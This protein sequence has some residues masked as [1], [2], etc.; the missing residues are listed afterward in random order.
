M[1]TSDAWTH[2]FNQEM[3]NWWPRDNPELMS[4]TQSSVGSSLCGKSKKKT[5]NI[6]KHLQFLWLK[7][8]L[9]KRKRS[10]QTSCALKRHKGRPK[11][12]YRGN[13]RSI[14]SI[15]SWHRAEWIISPGIFWWNLPRKT[16]QNTATSAM[17]QNKTSHVKVKFFRLRR[18]DGPAILWNVTLWGAH[19]ENPS[20]N[21]ST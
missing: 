5:E 9:K 21:P 15:P 3:A 14:W 8:F 17:I 1:D 6:W 18:L 11:N 2:A 19:N 20:E 4:S 16:W 12:E 10:S 13:S 7:W